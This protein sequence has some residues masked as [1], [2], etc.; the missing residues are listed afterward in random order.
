MLPLRD[1][2]LEA[3]RYIWRRW[4]AVASRL[5]RCGTSDGCQRQVIY[6]AAAAASFRQANR[7]W[8]SSVQVSWNIRN[9]RMIL[10]Q[11]VRV[12]LLPSLSVGSDYDTSIRL[13]PCVK[14]F[15]YSHWQWTG[16]FAASLMALQVAAHAKNRKRNSKS[17]APVLRRAPTVNRLAQAET[18]LCFNKGALRLSSFVYY[19]PVLQEIAGLLRQKC[20]PAGW[21]KHHVRS[22]RHGFCRGTVQ[23]GASQL[24]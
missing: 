5:F 18:L 9:T 23:S 20:G 10:I 12:C 14:A 3:T 1:C 8:S 15:V 17:S 22:P 16:S 6:A 24:R 13:S 4:R 11:R 21:R 2:R 19:Q 7:Y